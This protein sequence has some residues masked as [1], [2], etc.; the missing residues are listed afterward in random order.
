MEPEELSKF[1]SKQR[2]IPDY[3]HTPGF[4]KF[5]RKTKKEVVQPKVE[6]ESF[7]AFNG[8]GKSLRK[9]KKT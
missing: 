5:W 3:D 2:G 8:Q 1:V 7:E 9:T 6:E 4:I